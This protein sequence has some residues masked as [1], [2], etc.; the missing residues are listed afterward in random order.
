MCVHMSECMC[1]CVLHVH[2]CFFV[3]VPIAVINTITEK[4]LG[5]G[6]ISLAYTSASKKPGN[7]G[8]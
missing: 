8:S 4:L 6:G 2:V 3:R 1:A 7:R 5:E